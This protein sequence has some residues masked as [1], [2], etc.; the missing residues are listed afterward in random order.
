MKDC[1]LRTA[2]FNTAFSVMIFGMLAS[3]S[4]SDILDSL[5]VCLEYLEFTLFILIGQF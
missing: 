5:R 4:C 1:P 3:R 2:D